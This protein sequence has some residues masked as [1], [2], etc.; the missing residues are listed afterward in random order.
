MYTN[1]PIVNEDHLRNIKAIY[2]YGPSVINRYTVY[3]SNKR[4]WG[5]VSTKIFPCARV[6]YTTT[7]AYID[8]HDVGG[9]GKSNGKK[10]CFE[11]LPEICQKIILKDLEG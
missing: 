10:I 3:Y 1:I 9:L 7:K 11:L 8:T 4:E 2:D 5:I 6:S